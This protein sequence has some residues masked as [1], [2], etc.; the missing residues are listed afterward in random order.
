MI[1]PCYPLNIRSTGQGMVT[2]HITWLLVSRAR[3]AVGVDWGTQPVQDGIPELLGPD[4]EAK[5]WG[6]YSIKPVAS[7]RLHGFVSFFMLLQDGGI[8][9]FCVSA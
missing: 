9:L 5:Y 4:M 3:A 1:V 2:I 6:R 7:M 8:L